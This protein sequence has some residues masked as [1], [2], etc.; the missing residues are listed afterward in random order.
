MITMGDWAGGGGGAELAPCAST[1]EICWGEWRSFNIQILFT[2][3][4]TVSGTYYSLYCIAT[5]LDT[6][7]TCDCCIWQMGVFQHG[8]L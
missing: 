3:G 7:Q 6:V 8:L 4:P 2:V 5:V 1:S